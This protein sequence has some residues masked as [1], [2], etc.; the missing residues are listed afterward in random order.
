MADN[1]EV[2]GG[3]YMVAAGRA[4]VFYGLLLPHGL[5]ELTIIFVASGA[6]LRLGWSWI[7]PGLRTARRPWQRRRCRP[8]PADSHL[9]GPCPTPLG[10]DHDVRPPPGP[11]PGGRDFGSGGL[12]RR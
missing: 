2:T 9:P 3:G 5:L 7:A 4:G 10:F 11:V 8:R 6:G 1:A 12:R